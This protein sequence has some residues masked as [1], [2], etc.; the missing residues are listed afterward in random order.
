ME[1]ERE[2]EKEE[3]SDYKETLLQVGSKM[4]TSIT[5]YTTLLVA[6]LSPKW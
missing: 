6:F 5:Q 4:S 2:K 1:G 3:C